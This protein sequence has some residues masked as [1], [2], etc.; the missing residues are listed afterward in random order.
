MN[1]QK[2]KN[3]R[4]RDVTYTIEGDGGTSTTTSLRY[5]ANRI[6]EGAYMRNCELCD[7]YGKAG[8]TAG[9]WSRI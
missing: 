2:R 7:K 9:G 3:W 4:R 8:R 5:R 6:R 1:D